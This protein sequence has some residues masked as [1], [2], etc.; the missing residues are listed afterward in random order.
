M[1]KIF[2]SLKS[3][4]AATLV[5]AMAFSVSCSYDDTDIKHDIQKVKND[6]AALTERVAALET[7]LQSEVDSVKDLIDGKVVIVNVTTDED[8]TVLHPCIEY[9]RSGD[10]SVSP[11]PIA[12]GNFAFSRNFSTSG[13]SFA[14]PI[15]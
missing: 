9:P 6:L 14:P 4:V 13:S 11:Y 1:R 15:P 8:A 2:A 12:Y 5:A 7:K 10:V 3:V